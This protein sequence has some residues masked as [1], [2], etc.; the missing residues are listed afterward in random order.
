[1]NLG[2][3]ITRSLTKVVEVADGPSSE[4]VEEQRQGVCGVCVMAHDEDCERPHV[5]ELRVHTWLAIPYETIFVDCGGSRSGSYWQSLWPANAA[6]T[7]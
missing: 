4:Q 5:A 1:V 6:L 2:Q 3:T 7:R